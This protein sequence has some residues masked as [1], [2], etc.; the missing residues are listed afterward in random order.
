LNKNYP[1]R[2]YMLSKRLFSSNDGKPDKDDDKKEAPKG[3][4]KFFRNK[5]PASSEKETKENKEA[6]TEDKKEEKSE[7]E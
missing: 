2:D 1:L 7:N 5:K 3:F 6:E 4:E